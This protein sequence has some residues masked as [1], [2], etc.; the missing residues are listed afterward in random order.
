V[1]TTGMAARKRGPTATPK[2]PRVAQ[3]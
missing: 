1:A 3:A 2:D